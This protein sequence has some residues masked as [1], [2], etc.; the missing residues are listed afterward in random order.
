M[1]SEQP[2][3]PDNI[4][5]KV[6]DR[7]GSKS[8]KVSALFTHYKNPKA[9]KEAAKNDK[10]KS[11]PAKKESPSKR[12][13][14][15]IDFGASRIKLFQLAADGKDGYGVAVMDEEALDVSQGSSVGQTKQAIQKLVGRNPVGSNVIIGLPARECLTYNFTFPSMTDDE[16]REAVKWK[17]KQTKPFDLEVDKIKYTLL[18]WDSGVTSAAQAQQRVTVVCVSADNLAQKTTLL[19]E[20]GLKPV[21]AMI[22]PLALM[23]TR[24][25]GRLVKPSDELTLWLDLGS[26]ESVFIVEKNGVVLYMRNLSITGKVL[27][28]QIGQT[29]HV[30]DVE[31]EDLKKKYGLES[32]SPNLQ[33]LNVTEDEKISNPSLGVCLALTSMLENLVV[34][35]E[36]SF[37]HF[38]YQVTQSQIANFDR[39]VL[40][41]GCS[42]LKKLDQFLSDHLG[43]PVSK[44]EP[45]TALKLSEAI[46]N[47]RKNL[48]DDAL[49]FASAAGLAVTQAS[50]KARVYD[51]LSEVKRSSS[52]PLWEKIQSKPQ[53]AAI[54]AVVLLAVVTLP[55]AGALAFYKKQADSLNLQV[56]QTRG[57]INKRQSS[58]LEMAEQEKK[59]IEKKE[60]LEEK[61]MMFRESG[62]NEKDFSKLLTKIATLLP[63]E[64]WVTK[65]AYVDKKLTLVGATSRNELIV[66]FLD[67][68]K[69]PSEFSDV[70]F[71]YTQKDA[72]ASI[73]NFEVMMTVK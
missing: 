16:L 7:S 45:F 48:S 15:A 35:I 57:D 66:N 20:A 41:G 17:I 68:L 42:N 2:K 44:I 1:S 12:M 53:L 40:A 13:P 6:F 29:C 73:Y 24:R 46:T 22:S 32:W 38:S 26:D 25:F 51:L 36:H 31:A 43:V 5:K 58:Q 27:T 30:A 69:K 21:S 14:V 65:L 4:V 3:K 11:K 61:L 63:E 33:S 47:Q 60:M 49:I 70:V 10:T 9:K 50:D 19:S 62:R 8:D 56:K 71:N 39:V 55:Q 64:M 52:N 54:A 34:D 72:A 37:K 23:Q 59:L 18:K 28:R 67:N